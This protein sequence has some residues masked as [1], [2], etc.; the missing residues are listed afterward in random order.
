M[1][2]YI[3]SAQ[4][5]GRA[6][7]RSGRTVEFFGNLDS[8]FRESKLVDLGFEISHEALEDIYAKRRRGGMVYELE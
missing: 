6:R 4:Q 3:A 2:V 7:T 1:R 5:A 8:Q